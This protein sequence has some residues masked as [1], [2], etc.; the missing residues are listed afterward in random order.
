MRTARSSGNGQGELRHAYGSHF[1]GKG[2]RLGGLCAGPDKIESGTICGYCRGGDA[3]FGPV[4]HQAS[5]TKM[6]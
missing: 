3:N 2:K 4:E 6:T 1:G 5:L